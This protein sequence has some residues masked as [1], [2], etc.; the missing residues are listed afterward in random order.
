MGILQ[1]KILEWV[2]TPSSWNPPNPRIKPW[3]AGRFLTS[4]ATREAHSV[5]FPPFLLFCLSFCKVL[6]DCPTYFCNSALPSS[7]PSHHILRAEP[8]T[9]PQARSDQFRGAQFQGLPREGR[10]YSA[11]PGWGLGGLL[12]PPMWYEEVKPETLALNFSIP[13]RESVP[14]PGMNCL[15]SFW[16]N[17][18][19]PIL[20]VIHQ[21][22]KRSQ[23]FWRLRTHLAE[24]HIEKPENAA[25]RDGRCQ[26]GLTSV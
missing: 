9:W 8:A 19:F 11:R 12:V 10:F 23:L 7:C 16:I 22:G 4:W 15:D 2:A 20:S 25:W 18:L 21:G 1:A 3:T 5:C 26:S 6:A 17:S 13:Q 14:G 24:K